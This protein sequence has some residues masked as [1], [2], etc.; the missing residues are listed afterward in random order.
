M[1]KQMKLSHGLV[2]LRHQA[3]KWGT[4]CTAPHLTPW[5]WERGKSSWCKFRYAT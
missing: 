2:V 5:W 3:T 4:Y 1:N